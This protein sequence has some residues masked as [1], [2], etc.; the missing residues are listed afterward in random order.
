MQRPSLM[1][2]NNL[3]FGSIYVEKYPEAKNDYHAGD[4]S[5]TITFDGKSDFIFFD[6]ND[7]YKLSSDSDSLQTPFIPGLFALEGHA[8]DKNK[9]V[10][11][12]YDNQISY[13]VNAFCLDKLF[14][15]GIRSVDV[16]LIKM[17]NSTLSHLDN[18]QLLEQSQY[19][20]KETTGSKVPDVFNRSS[21]DYSFMNH[22]K[23]AYG[24]PLISTITFEMKPA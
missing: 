24:K 17:A 5:V 12:Y 8:E 11:G 23:Y 4:L 14:R 13:D 16:D 10:I 15:T 2:Q 6:G 22:F 1:I 7:E 20:V 3:Q 19:Q 18:A 21:N 9:P